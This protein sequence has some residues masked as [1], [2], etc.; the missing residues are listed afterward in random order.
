MLPGWFYLTFLVP[1]VIIGLI[2][3]H[4]MAYKKNKDRN[5]FLPITGF[6]LL[7]L[8]NILVYIPLPRTYST[9]VIIAKVL[10]STLGYGLILVFMIMKLQGRSAPKPAA[11]KAAGKKKSK[12]RK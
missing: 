12:K 7:L 8:Q 11:P 9:A 6:S 1:I 10:L 2:I 4:V 3:T 5:M